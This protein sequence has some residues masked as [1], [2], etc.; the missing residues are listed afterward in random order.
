MPRRENEDAG[1]IV[2]VPT[3]LLLAEEADNLPT[4]LLRVGDAV[5]GYIVHEEV[6]VKGSDVV[7]DRFVVE[8]EFGEKG[9]V[10][11][12]ELSRGVS[13]DVQGCCK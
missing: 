5:V 2:V 11:A 9:K 6:V 8:E 13:M 1:E 7:E 3:H 12:K 4:L 10:L